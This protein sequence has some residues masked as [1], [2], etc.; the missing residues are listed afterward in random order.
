MGDAIR[1]GRASEIL[2]MIEGTSTAL[3]S[4]ILDGMG[5][6]QQ[7]MDYAIKPLRSDT[8]VA[9]RAFTMIA[10]VVYDKR[11]GHY[12]QLFASYD[13][14]APGDVIVIGTNS[15]LHS[16]IWGELLSLGAVARGA[17]GVVMDGLTR[18]PAEIA[19]DGFPCFARGTSPID[20]D[21]R[22]DITAYGTTI[23]CG[24]VT[25]RQG[26]YLVGDEMG[27][28]AIPEHIVA[29]VAEKARAKGVGELQV[30][31]DLQAGVSVREVF[32]RYGIL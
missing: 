25:I 13:H 9:G 17:K 14:M 11:P 16:G 7:A 3:L 4:D 26:D 32:N 22:L 18:D 5:Y 30:R 19:R 31:A 8:K 20:S 15:A 10:S 27:V 12:D 1:N 28:V 21:G 6:R 24:G 2:A 29:E 23:S